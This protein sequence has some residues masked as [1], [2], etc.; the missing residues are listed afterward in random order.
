[1]RAPNVLLIQ[2]DQQKAS[3]LDIYNQD[4]NYIRVENISQLA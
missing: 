1:V 2:T 3:S 4:I